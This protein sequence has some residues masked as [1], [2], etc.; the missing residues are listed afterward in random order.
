[1]TTMTRKTI[2]LPITMEAKLN[3]A[4]HDAGVSFSEYMR[5]LVEKDLENNTG[6]DPFDDYRFHGSPDLASNVDDMYEEP[7]TTKQKRVR[8]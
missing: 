3:R 1:M 4:A 6:R 5:Q 7:T 2:T 8:K